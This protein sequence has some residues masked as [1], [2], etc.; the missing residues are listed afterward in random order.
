MRFDVDDFVARCSSAVREKDAPQRIADILREVI[1]GP[2]AITKAI[3]SR[4]E[5]QFPAPMFA[6]P[7][8][9]RTGRRTCGG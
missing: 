6:A 3:A 1:A 8:A 5:G 9:G 4:R 7:S 2:E